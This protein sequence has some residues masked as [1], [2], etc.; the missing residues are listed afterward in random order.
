LILYVHIGVPP[1]KGGRGVAGGH[2]IS[3]VASLM[4]NYK[5]NSPQ[6]K[7]KK[8]HTEKF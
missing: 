5:E 1:K 4:C 2:K 7:K 6:N 3:F 8:E